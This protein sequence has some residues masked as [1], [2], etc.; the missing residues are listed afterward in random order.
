VIAFE[1]LGEVQADDDDS[2]GDDDDSGEPVEGCDCEASL[3]ASP[4]ASF[5]WLP[6]V[7]AVALRRRR[8][9]SSP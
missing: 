2:T 5:L 1:V 8:G 3:A 9:D 4:A 7:L 6:L